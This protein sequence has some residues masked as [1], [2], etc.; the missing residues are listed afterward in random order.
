MSTKRISR[1]RKVNALDDSNVDKTELLKAIPEISPDI[2]LAARRELCK[3]DIVAYANLI[4]IPNA[5]RD[6]DDTD[7][8]NFDY[9]ELDTLA[10]HHKLILTTGQ[11]VIEGEYYGAMIFAPPGSAKSTYASLILPCWAMVT[12]KNFKVIATSYGDKR[13]WSQSRLMQAL[14]SS[15]K[16]KLLFP[17][18]YI[19][20]NNSAVD[21][22]S[23][24]N[25]SEVIAA[26]IDGQLTG[27]RADLGIA[28][29]I[30]KGA[31]Q[32]DSELQRNRL[33]ESYISNFT[34]RL[35]P[36]AGQIIINTRWN[37][38]DV[39][40]RLLPSD[41]NGESGLIKCN[42]GNEWLVICLPAICDRLDDPLKRK[43]G[44]SLWPE[45]YGLRTGNPEDYWRTY[46]TNPRV[47]NSLYQQKPTNESG[48]YFIRENFNKRFDIKDLQDNVRYY[49]TVDYAVT[50]NGGDFSAISIWA[51]YDELNDTR[52]YR[53]DGWFGKVKVDKVIK[54]QVNLT[55]KYNVLKWFF[56][57]DLI[58]KAI[59]NTV[60]REFSDNELICFFEAIPSN[61][62]KEAKCK[63]AQK[64]AQD[65]IVYIRDDHNGDIFIEEC[66]KFPTGRN[67]DNVDT[68][69]IIGRVFHTLTK[70]NKV[71]QE[72]N[73]PVFIPSIRT[74]FNGDKYV[75]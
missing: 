14:I 51:V 15:P 37:Q 3:T 22:W 45:W 32:A 7:E 48:D 63:P 72:I 13:A 1:V 12:K 50:P 65:G 60:K 6:F 64:L 19:N 55:K 26:S 52:L 61:T 2:I 62:S 67:D 71:K 74:P 31:E 35:K 4:A 43:I 56:E 16:H 73:R 39:C 9:L 38:D 34:T 27:N 10:D 44:E 23:L 33:Y 40:G 57:K 68:F 54:E 11:K 5:P 53:V 66:L 75:R 42:D 29:D 17:D 28:D 24:N 41:W 21:H 59:D 30:V 49:G 47:W 25:N 8:S 58:T 46:R 69:S 36:K 20:K 18:V 70:S